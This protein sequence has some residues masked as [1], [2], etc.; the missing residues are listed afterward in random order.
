MK[1]MISLVLVAVFVLSL[2][3]CGAAVPAVAQTVSTAPTD[4]GPVLLN[5]LIEGD[6]SVRGGEF[7]VAIR[8]EDNPGVISLQL[9]LTYDAERLEL[10]EVSQQ[11][12]VGITHSALDASPLTIAWCDDT[13]GDNDTDGVVAYLTFRVK[14]E[15]NLGESYL[16]LSCQREYVYNAAQEHPA[17]S[18]QSDYVNLVEYLAGDL[19][20]D[21]RINNRDLGLLMKWIN[22]TTVSI[23]ER[24]ADTNGDGTVNN[25]DLGLLQRYLNGWN[26]TLAHPAPPEPEP[27]VSDMFLEQVPDELSGQKIKMLV[28][29]NAA[30]EDKAKADTFKDKTGIQLTYETAAKDKYLTKL[31]AMILAGNPPAL[32]TIL[33]EQYLLTITRGV[34]QPIDMTSL[35]GLGDVYAYDLME[36]FSYNGAYYGIA[37]KGSYANNFAMMYFN[38]TM[39]AADVAA[40]TDPYSLWKQGQWN[41]ATWME[42]A[43]KYTDS[44]KGVYGTAITNHN[45][46]MLSAGQDVVTY[47]KNSLTNNIR[48]S[49]LTNAWLHAW[50][51]VHTNKVVSAA[52][53]NAYQMFVNGQVAML[54][55]GAYTMLSR[56][57]G[58]LATDMQDDWGIV[59]F[60]SPMGMNPVSACE[61]SVWGF[62]TG[63]TGKKLEAAVWYLHYYLGDAYFS[64]TDV[65]PV[66]EGAEV[67]NWMWTQRMQSYNSVGTLT[68]GGAYT[69]DAISQ[70]IINESASKAMV[71]VNLDSWYKP[72][73][74]QIDAIMSEYT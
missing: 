42:L 21:A 16:Q 5:F 29:W 66:A 60:P 51:M 35:S 12:F 6:T 26:V 64:E 44:A 13:N 59:P 72:I 24:A 62:P 37:M 8:T 50:D 27:S 3:V 17:C 7:T 4:L 43:D 32:A 39:M 47:T 36:Q 11:D 41:W 52:T 14:Q 28:W 53:D 68:Y 49:M 65:F 58:K 38:K 71:Y 56:F 25:R 55:D 48:N 15:A 40:G 22:G 69:A 46:W 30:D 1:R 61:G 57:G 9:S 45:Y 20:A 34:M 2:M 18:V 31:S 54:G 63:V 23:D 73:N 19:N 10:L 74:A 67:V 70:K 33:S